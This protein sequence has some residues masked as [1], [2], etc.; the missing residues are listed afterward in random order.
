VR[1]DSWS[2][3]TRKKVD[4]KVVYRHQ[5]CDT[6][7]TVRIETS[8][9]C[10]VCHTVGLGNHVHNRPER[11]PATGLLYGR[12]HRRFENQPCSGCIS[13]LADNE[14]RIAEIDAATLALTEYRLNKSPLLDFSF[15]AEYQ[16]RDSASRAFYALLLALTEG[17]R[18]RAEYCDGEGLAVVPDEK[19]RSSDCNRA[20][21]IG[22]MTPAAAAAFQDLYEMFVEFTDGAYAAGKERGQ[23]ILIQLQSGEIGLADFNSA[24]TKRR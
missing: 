15:S 14:K 12:W 17:T 20:D 4:K 3:I 19:R 6:V 11:E 22:R 18:R 10:P 5:K 9:E 13:R 23:N 21:W 7:L 1:S 8:K 24:L 16:R 2:G